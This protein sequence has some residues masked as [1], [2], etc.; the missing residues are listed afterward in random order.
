VAPAAI[1]AVITL[2]L[3][4]VLQDFGPESTIRQF[5]RAVEAKDM[6]EALSLTTDGERDPSSIDLATQIDWLMRVGNRYQIRRVQRSGENVVA[7]VEYRQSNGPIRVMVWVI[8]K[9]KGTTRWKINAAKTLNLL[10]NT[11]GF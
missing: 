7:A 6:R 11:L 5:H 9:P 2:S 10:K 1:L 4:F 3:F 8:E